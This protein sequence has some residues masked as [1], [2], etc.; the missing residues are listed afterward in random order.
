[1]VLQISKVD[2]TVDGR[3]QPIE[4]TPSSSKRGRPAGDIFRKAFDN[5]SYLWNK[6]TAYKK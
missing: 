2:A 4:N 1:M 5:E 6:Y 3:A